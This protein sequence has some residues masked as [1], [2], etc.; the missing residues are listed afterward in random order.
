MYLIPNH[1]V[2]KMPCMWCGKPVTAESADGPGVCVP[3]DMGM[4]T[5]EV[6]GV[7]RKWIT[8]DTEYKQYMSRNP[9]KNFLSALNEGK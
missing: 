1:L 9:H 7:F 2:G 5:D 6:T 4:K 8:S 3:C